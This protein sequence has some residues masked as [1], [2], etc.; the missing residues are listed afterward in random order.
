MTSE[1]DYDELDVSSLAFW[2]QPGRARDKVFAELRRH[3]SVSFQRPPDFGLAGMAAGLIPGYWLVA[4]HSL[5][6]SVSRSPDLFCSG[7]GALLDD[8]GFPQDLR[9]HV[10]SFLVM[11]GERH[12]TLRKLVLK[13]FTPRQLARIESQIAEQ[14]KRVVD[15]L[16]DAGD[17]DFVKEVA[18]PLPLWTISEMLGIPEAARE[19]VVDAANTLFAA[20]DPA[21][22]DAGAGAFGQFVAATQI[23]WQTAVELAQARQATPNDDLMTALVQ[24]EVDGQRLSDEEIGAFMLLLTSA[25]TETTRTTLSHTVKALSDFPEQ[26]ALLADDP[27]AVLPT[28][29]EEFVRWTTPV[30]HM[31]RT[32]AR[33]TEL[34][35]VP[36][37]AGDSVVLLYESGNH[38]EQVFR[39]PWR[40]DVT[41][42]PNDH[43]GFGGGGPH[44]CLG[45][46]LAKTQLRCVVTELVTR[47]PNLSVGE[48]D[49]LTSYFSHGITRLPCS[50]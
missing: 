50:V 17:C 24:A 45:A 2:S 11:D 1:P 43:V 36:I 38:D 6:R 19:V 7:Q 39:D 29:I 31:R 10:G 34:A 33:D 35:G 32:A 25:G 8:I 26:R 5:I 47:V 18:T 23:I 22:L 40:F 16:L 9:E 42:H 14:A 27:A 15:R 44:Y 41:R 4:S 12:A 48:P 3:R 21:F 37:G 20:N 49:Y 30:I 28:A 46:H 13:A